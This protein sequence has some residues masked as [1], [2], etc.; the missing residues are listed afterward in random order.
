MNVQCAY[1]R[2]EL[3]VFVSPC[4]PLLYETLSSCSLAR[5]FSVLFPLGS[6]RL[7][8][9]GFFTLRSDIFSF[10][11]EM[12]WRLY[13]F[14]LGERDCAKKFEITYNVGAVTEH[15][16]KAIKKKGMKV[17]G[18][19]LYKQIMEVRSSYSLDAV[20]SQTFSLP[21]YLTFRVMLVASKKRT[22]TIWMTSSTYSCL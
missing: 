6:R 20:I 16:S 3:R 4:S 21:I 13:S 18:E 22:Q 11:V 1:Y 5:T 2:S 12:Q 14:R 15:F 19:F 17:P 10:G 8:E 7:H 9:Q